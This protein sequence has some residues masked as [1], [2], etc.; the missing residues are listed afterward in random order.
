VLGATEMSIEAKAQEAIGESARGFTGLPKKFSYQR[1]TRERRQVLF[2][3]HLA[4][5]FNKYTHPLSPG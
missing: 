4:L 5:V 1:E 2:I 3:I